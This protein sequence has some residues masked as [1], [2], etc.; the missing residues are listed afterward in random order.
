MSLSADWLCL[1]FFQRVET[2]F[3]WHKFYHDSL[4][5]DNVYDELGRLT[6]SN[7]ILDSLKIQGYLWNTYDS[8]D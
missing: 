8:E 3:Y 4:N 2:S 7:E 1:K 5:L 6:N